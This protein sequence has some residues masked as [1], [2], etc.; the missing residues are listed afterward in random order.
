MTFLIDAYN[1]MHAVGYLTKAT[2][3][4]RMESSRRRLLDWLAGSAK[5]RPADRFHVVFDAT[6]ATT[7]MSDESYKG[8]TVSYAVGESADAYL[9]RAFSNVKSGTVAVVT[10]DSEIREAARRKGV[11]SLLCSAFV[12]R[13]LAVDVPSTPVSPRPEKPDGEVMDDELLAA[14]T[15]P[16]PATGPSG[17]PARRVRRPRL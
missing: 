14:F 10:N 12:D 9:I 11:D 8:L 1:L 17:L 16:R 4:N 2:P 3:A 13:L 15:Q 7:P 5:S 6:A